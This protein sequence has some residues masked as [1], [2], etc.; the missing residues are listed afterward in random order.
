M[1]AI[2]RALLLLLIASL[3]V[4][5]ELC[6]LGGAGLNATDLLFPLL[7]ATWIFA[8]AKGEAP[9]PCWA[10][11]RPVLLYICS[12]AAA[13]IIAQNWEPLR[14]VILF[15]ALV[16]T[17]IVSESAGSFRTLVTPVKD[18]IAA[19]ALAALIGIAAALLFYAGL[20]M[21]FAI[22]PY[23]TLLPGPYPRIDST[24]DFPAMLT[25]YLSVSV[26]L[27][28]FA[29]HAGWIGRRTMIGALTV[30][31]LCCAFTL[32]PGLGGLA[33][34]LGAWM[35]LGAGRSRWWLGGGLL[36]LLVSVV[37]AGLTPIPHPDASWQIEVLGQTFYPSVRWLTWGQA[38]GTWS[39][40]WLVGSGLTVS[41]ISV[42]YLDPS[43]D[44]HHLT[45]AHNVFLNVAA[46]SGVVGLAGL[47]VL[48]VRVGIMRLKAPK[49]SLLQALTI[50]WLAAFVAQGLTGSYEDARHLWVLLGLIIAARRLQP[51][52]D[53]VRP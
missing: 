12:I 34:G 42:D 4:P 23:G 51:R 50:A 30:L 19:S 6:R 2:Q 36:M 29:A 1:G 32:T 53:P 48:I 13:A 52:P 40:H 38:M 45:D 11:Y 14:L 16:L 15:Y 44:W 9:S 49:G 26:I 10:E 47:L 8:R 18:W 7:C 20:R 41:P 25:N 17:F 24:F 27:T 46:Q 43:G 37:A 5:I 28:L 22:H 3:A 35:T 21:E 33:L 39:A 31:L